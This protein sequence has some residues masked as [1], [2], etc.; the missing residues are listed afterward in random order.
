MV[1]IQRKPTHSTCSQ[2]TGTAK[3][4]RD[5]QRQQFP[6][7][8]P[9]KADFLLDNWVK[10]YQYLAQIGLNDFE[11]GIV[12]DDSDY[13][14]EVTTKQKDMKRLIKSFNGIRVKPEKKVNGKSVLEEIV[15]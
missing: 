14:Y 7:L 13:Y 3:T 9:K 1:R 12:K 4:L 10:L 11:V 15:S 8:A 2:S 6:D 5:L